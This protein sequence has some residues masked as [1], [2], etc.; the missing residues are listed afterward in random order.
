DEERQL[1]EQT[2]GESSAEV[3]EEPLR[4]ERGGDETGEQSGEEGDA[5]AT[6]QGL[7]DDAGEKVDADER[8]VENRKGGRHEPLDIPARHEHEPASDTDRRAGEEEPGAAVSHGR[9][10]LT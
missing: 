5:A 10:L 1:L 3:A 8:A 9:S 2:D 6:E 7:D 4:A